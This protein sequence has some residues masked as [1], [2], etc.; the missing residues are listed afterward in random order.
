[1]PEGFKAVSRSLLHPV[2]SPAELGTSCN[3]HPTAE[4]ITLISGTESDQR[5]CCGSITRT[6]KP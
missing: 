3:L 4:S 2:S 5:C 1:M 6:R